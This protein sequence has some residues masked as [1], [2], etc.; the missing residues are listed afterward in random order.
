MAMETDVNANVG[1]GSALQCPRCLKTF[2]RKSSRQR[3]IDSDTA[4][5]NKVD[6][7]VIAE[8]RRVVVPVETLQPAD[9]ELASLLSAIPSPYV[10]FRLVQRLKVAHPA[11]GPHIFNKPVGNKLRT[12]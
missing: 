7:L 6:N 8:R 5:P 11:C 1:V 3:H 4:C 12:L 2:G 10:R 9:S